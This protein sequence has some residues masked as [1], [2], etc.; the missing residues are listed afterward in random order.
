VSSAFVGLEPKVLW[1]YFDAVSQ[2]PRCSGK[3]ERILAYLAELGA[4]RKLTVRRDKVGNLV[5]ALPATAGCE[6]K[7]TVVLQG[8]VDMV[9]EKN[10]DVAHDFDTQGI[11][12]VRDGDWLTAKGTTL[13]G[14]NGV[15][16]AAMLAL[17]DEPPHKHGPL[18]LLFTVDEERGLTGAGGI[19]PHML[20]GRV[21]MNLDSEEEGFVTVGCAGGGDTVLTLEGRREDL[22]AGW[23]RAQLSVRGLVGGHS[24][25]DIISNR[26]NALRCLGRALDRLGRE[27]G[28]LRL[29][30]LEGGSKRNAI[31]REASAALA[32]PAGG[33]AR[34]AQVLERVVADLKAEFSPTDPGLALV[35]EEGAATARPFDAATTTRALTLLLALPTGVLAMSRG[36]A[37]LVETSTNLGVVE[38]EGDKLRFVSCTRSSVGPALEGVRQGLRVLGEAV[39]AAVV[40][41][42]A[43]PGWNPDLTSKLLATF[44]RV[45]REVTGKE[46]QVMAIHA[47]LECGILGERFPG[48]DMI[49]F[50]PDLKG[51]HAPGEKLSIPST[52]RFFSL[53]K[54]LLEALAS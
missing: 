45:H 6:S 36:I 20:K 40:Q 18:E 5:I 21:M 41:E 11:E 7:P 42:P 34:A 39:G 27:L 32:L 19:E 37:G 29:C 23:E 31:P 2:I 14:D 10:R 46:P 26:A 4:R 9:C 15:A 54:S 30:A 49:S 52:G 8:H 17:L 22:L 35:L 13:G 48:M 25:M 16:L 1:N 53:L 50:G 47:G 51:V 44:K 28:G 3:E 33:R 12:V 43:Y 24:G 38:A